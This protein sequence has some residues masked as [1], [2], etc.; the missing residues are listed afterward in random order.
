MAAYWGCGLEAE[1]AF[2]CLLVGHGTYLPS[3]QNRTGLSPSP[4]EGDNSEVLGCGF[5]L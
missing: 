2:C 3:A 1:V 5:S 4:L